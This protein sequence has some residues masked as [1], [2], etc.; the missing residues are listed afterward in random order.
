MRV[1]FRRCLHLRK[2]AFPAVPDEDEAAKATRLEAL[3]AA[4]EAAKAEVQQ[5]RG[6]EK[7]QRTS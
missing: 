7:Q 5:A 1:L 2:A 3:A 4:V 6:A